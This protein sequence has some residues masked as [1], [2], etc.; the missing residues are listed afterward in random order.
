MSSEVLNRPGVLA[1]VY[2]QRED[3]R[4]GWLEKTVAAASGR[5]HQYVLGRHPRYRHFIDSVEAASTGIDALTPSELQMRVRELRRKL[6]ANGLQDEL[7]HEA[8]AA[9]REIASRKLSMRHYDVQLF[10]GWVMLRGKVAEMETGEGKTL[11]ATL[12]AGT[13][14]MAGIPVHI[15]TVNDF[16]ASR[17]AKWMKPIY[18]ALGL[19]VG[20]VT[21]GLDL[22]QRRDAYRCDITYCTNKQ[23]VF[24]Y[25]KDRMLLGAENRG[26]HLNLEELY[27]RQPRTSRMLLRG[28]CFAIVDEADS[29]LVD[30]ART[31]LIISNRS[32]SSGQDKTYQHAIRIAG[33]L[34]AKR[35]YHV[36]PFRRQVEL[37]DLSKAAAARMSKSLGGVW[38]GPR[39]RE[40]L[41]KQGLSALHLFKLD[42]HY[43]VRDGKVQIIDEFTGR[44]MADRS[45]ERGLHQMI[46]AKERCPITG[47][48]ETLSRISY[49]RFFQRYLKLA[50]MTGTAR[51]VASELWSVYR[52]NVVTVPTN[53]PVR[54]STSPDV[55]YRT[56]DEKWQ[57]A[58]EQVKQLNREGRPVL[59]GTRSVEAS[60]LISRK[61]SDA[62]LSHRVLNARQDQKEAEIVSQAGKPRRI[63]VAT[64]MAGRGTDIRLADGIA[65]LGGLHVLA[66]ERHE[67]RRIDRQLFGRAGRQG[68]PGSYQAIL[69]L[70]DELFSDLMGDRTRAIVERVSRGDGPLNPWLTRMLVLLAQRSAEVRQSGVRRDLLKLDENL[71]DMLAFSGRGE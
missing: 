5:F 60:E 71:G 31:P 66:T 52:L 54:R 2:P 70:D 22:D 56:A 32:D 68:D 43:L 55:L 40:E 29:V 26:L 51:E 11:T 8:F 59:V 27:A 23:L 33:N 7:V 63:T 28:L 58:V 38:S 62:G 25:L 36:D 20:V 37:T 49:Q 14:A 35:D 4:A 45:W 53:K 34:T 61:L 44:I 65:E 64:N 67:A 13:A 21:D 50:G 39:R 41:V 9:I 46:E 47:R 12:A 16:L 1:G 10:G 6:Y 17:D 24:D 57:A 48:Q 19:T 3:I 42:K 18:N 15:V 69:S 30:E